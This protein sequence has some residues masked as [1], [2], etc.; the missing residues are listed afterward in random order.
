MELNLRFPKVNQVVIKFDD[1]E[2]EALEF[3]SP[4]SEADLK[5]IQWY[6]ET[7]AAQYTTDVD[8]K[9][10]QRIAEQ[11]PEWGEALFDAVF[12]DRAAQRLFNSFQDEDEEG[13][14]VTISASYP[15]ILSLPWELLRDPKGTYLVH[16]TPR[17]SIRR[18]FAGAGGGRKLFEVKPKDRLRLLF[19][20][21]RPTGAG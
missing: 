17:I 14:L 7:Y 6:L 16:D 11:L 15:A 21:S 10:A 19:V 9:R 1:N 5:D 18:R 8:D 2:T 12:S 20:I 13:K 3:V 4:I